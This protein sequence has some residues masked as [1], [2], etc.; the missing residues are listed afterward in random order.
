MNSF[1]RALDPDIVGDEHYRVAQGVK[2]VLQE[3]KEL[4]DII[5]ILGQEEL[6]DDQKVTVQRA[7]RVQRFLSQPFHVAEQFTGRGGKYVPLE[8]TIRGFAEILD[9]KHDDLPE[10]AFYMVGTIDEAVEKAKELGG[11]DAEDAPKD[12]AEAP[13]SDSKAG[14]NED[15]AEAAQQET[16]EQKPAAEKPRGQAEQKA[17]GEKPAEDK[18]AEAKAAEQKADDEKPAE[19]KPAEA[20]AAMEKKPDDEE[21]DDEKQAQEKAAPDGDADEGKRT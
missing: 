5:A 9:G 10:D 17:D 21:P 19:E 11:G 6:S 2:R 13:Q 14:E 15:A 7:R 8:E 12:K 3:Y 18:P 4:Q 1:S 16:D 20:K